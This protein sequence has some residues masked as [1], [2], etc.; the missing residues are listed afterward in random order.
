ML[1]IQ[2]PF[3]KFMP[4]KKQRERVANVFRVRVAE[5]L[6]REREAVKQN[7]KMVA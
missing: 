4:K 1:V 5:K 7:L 3:L 6:Q 2:L